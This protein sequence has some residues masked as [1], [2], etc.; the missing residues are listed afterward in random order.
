MKIGTPMRRRSYGLEWNCLA[1]PWQLMEL[2]QGPS[3]R[4]E[5]WS[6]HFCASDGVPC[7][8][9]SVCD[10]EPLGWG[11]TS[12]APVFRNLLLLN[13]SIAGLEPEFR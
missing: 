12:S 5:A 9:F 1:L 11:Q 6:A 2:V 13:N 3:V 7:S 4:E 10:M 8:Q